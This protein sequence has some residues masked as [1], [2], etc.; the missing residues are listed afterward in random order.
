MFNSHDVMVPEVGGTG[1]DPF[2][3]RVAMGGFSWR[4]IPSGKASGERHT[5]ALWSL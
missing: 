5:C 3:A 1:F 2:P 4:G